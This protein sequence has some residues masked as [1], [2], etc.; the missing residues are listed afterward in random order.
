MLGRRKVVERRD[1]IATSKLNAVRRQMLREQSANIIQRNFRAYLA[2]NFA[3]RQYKLRE[4]QEARIAL[5]ERMVRLIQRICYGKLGRNKM[6]RR[7]KYLAKLANEFDMSKEIQRI[8]R[9]HVG[10]MIAEKRFILIHILIHLLINILIHTLIH[11]I[12]HIL[13]RILIHIFIHILIHKLIYIYSY[14]YS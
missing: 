13:M 5:R 12:I 10:R 2:V 3:V 1:E 11:I 9:G 8:Y 14:I 7:R 6:K 4:K